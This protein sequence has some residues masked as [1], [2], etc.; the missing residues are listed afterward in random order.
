MRLDKHHSWWRHPAFQVAA[1]ALITSAIGILNDFVYDDVPII[2]ENVRIHSLQNFGA[3]VT[4]PWWPPPF[5]EQLYRPLAALLLA[6]QWVIG[7][8]SAAPFRLFSIALYLVSAVLFY[9]L[10]TRLF[11]NRIA[12]VAAAL[13]A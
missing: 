11:P 5:V 4:K 2:L 12:L 3:I 8:G 7:S 9:R 13:F 1:L 6:V 10:A